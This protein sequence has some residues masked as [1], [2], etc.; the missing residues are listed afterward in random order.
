[1][2]RAVLDLLADSGLGA[3]CIQTKD[4]IIKKIPSNASMFR[5]ACL[6]RGLW[7]NI[8]LHILIVN[9]GA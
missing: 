2:V 7:A 8:S 9:Q 4:A 5:V 1:M 6:M 3:R